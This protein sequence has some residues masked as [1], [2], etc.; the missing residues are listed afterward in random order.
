MQLHVYAGMK[1]TTIWL[2]SGKYMHESFVDLFRI[3]YFHFLMF[4]QFQ[5]GVEKNQWFLKL[6]ICFFGFLVFFNGFYGFFV[7]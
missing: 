3:F 6:E 1:R 4:L 7:F 5:P 2:W